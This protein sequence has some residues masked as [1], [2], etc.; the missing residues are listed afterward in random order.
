MK[1]PRKTVRWLGYDVPVMW[2][3]IGNTVAFILWI[4]SSCMSAVNYYVN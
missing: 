4:F 3:V 2:I 1:K